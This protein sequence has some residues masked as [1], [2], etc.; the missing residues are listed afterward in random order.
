MND[1]H[2]QRF[3]DLIDIF[4][5]RFFHM[6]DIRFFDVND[7]RFRCLF[8]FIICGGVQQV[9]RDELELAS[10][11][12]NLQNVWKLLQKYTHAPFFQTNKYRVVGIMRLVCLAPAALLA[13]KPSHTWLL[14]ILQGEKKKRRRRRKQARRAWIEQGRQGINTNLFLR[15]AFVR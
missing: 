4:D 1:I 2:F 3:F 13:S 14:L 9:D 11:S 10:E 12:S 7:L 6:N 5:W 15:P 8:I